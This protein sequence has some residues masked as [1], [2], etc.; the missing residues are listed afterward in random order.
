MPS[1][2]KFWNKSAFVWILLAACDTPPAPAPAFDP[3]PYHQA[4][5]KLGKT[6]DAGAQDCLACHQGI[7]DLSLG[8][9]KL[10]EE[11]RFANAE[12][13]KRAEKE[14]PDAKERQ[15]MLRVFGAHS[16]LDVLALHPNV[17]CRTCHVTTDKSEDKTLS[18]ERLKV[19]REYHMQYHPV[20]KDVAMRKTDRTQAVCLKC[21]LGDEPVPHADVLNRARLIYD[22][23]GCYACHTTHGMKT[24]E[25]DLAPGEK[26]MRRPGPP[27]ANIASK[28]DKRW[29]YNWVYVPPRFKPTARMFPF[30]P[31][32]PIGLP[33]QVIAVDPK[34]KLT[35]EAYGRVVV[36]CIVE[37]LY[38]K[39]K[40][41]DLP[42]IPAGLLET[43]DWKIE[44]QRTR[45]QAIAANIGC[46]ACHKFD[47]N[48]PPNFR[49]AMGFLED[50]FATNLYG[51]GDKFDSP[52]G[53][54]WLFHWLKKPHAFNSDSPMP[55][56]DLTDAEVAD[57]VQYLVSLKIDNAFRKQNQFET[58]EPSELPV[59][60]DHEPHPEWMKLLDA[61][62]A[63]QKG[64]ANAS[65]KDKILLVG[66]AM[67]DVFT[68]FSCHDLGESEW[69]DK[70][71]VW[72]A[73]NHDLFPTRGLMARMPLYDLT[74]DE[75]GLSATYMWAHTEALDGKPRELSARRKAMV[76]GERLLAKYNCAGCHI[77]EPTTLY[78]RDG[79][80]VLASAAQ[81]KSRVE[82]PP[83][84]WA[85]DWLRLPVTL[86]YSPLQKKHPTLVPEEL[87][88][89]FEQIRGGTYIS[90]LPPEPPIEDFRLPP[91]LRTAGRKFNPEW[92]RSFLRVPARM[93]PTVP[94]MPKFNLSAEEI[95]ALVEYFRARDG[96]TPD[97]AAG[98]LTEAQIDAR[99]PALAEAD[100]LLRTGCKQ[101]HMIDG[102]GGDMSVDLTEVHKRLQRPWLRAFL[103]EPGS[104][105]P[106]SVMP[107]LT[108][109]ANVDDVTDALLNYPLLRRAKVR[110]GDADEMKQA[111]PYVDDELVRLALD[112]IAN[113]PKLEKAAPA[114]IDVLMRKRLPFRAELEALLSHKSAG[115]RRLAIEGLARIA[116]K[117]SLPKIVERLADADAS[118]RTAALLA[119]GYFGDAPSVAKLLADSDP[120]VRKTA[121]RVLDEAGAGAADVAGRL[122]DE[123]GNVRILAAETLSSLGARDQ[124]PALRAALGDSDPDV[125]WAVLLALAHLGDAGDAK[126]LDHEKASIRAAA[127][128][129]LIRDPRGMAAFKKLI[130]EPPFDSM[131]QRALQ[132]AVNSLSDLQAG[133]EPG[134][135]TVA[136]WLRAIDAAA[137]DVDEDKLK[138][139]VSCR[140]KEL[141]VLARLLS[142]KTG[143]VFL[144]R[145][146]KL[147]FVPLDAALDKLK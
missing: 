73:I 124:I 17:D 37:Y 116:A 35:V 19:W 3:T 139:E 91:M 104:I 43:E 119:A 10:G 52:L 51:S 82:G 125:V 5:A 32:G 126:F 84:K 18:P 127:A 15:K 86:D 76:E 45:G 92:L 109:D 75:S 93:R 83:A 57:L 49:G 54:K 140:S 144:T 136:D 120:D 40:P 78:V 21:H 39:S 20:L 34:D 67:T 147:V 90:R 27:L 96:A 94:R 1:C 100:R 122:K 123:D 145:D 70:P 81:Y 79:G 58:W 117:E 13:Q 25:Q 129:C 6:A 72:G 132:H 8:T 113:D 118:V 135:R 11:I 111:L 22:R 64:P 62:Y 141:A 61:L 80:R 23:T 12:L 121:L 71:V 46:I 85:V 24:R 60:V 131:T 38:N 29:M 133:V 47:E 146:G 65:T 134:T 26:R 31:R 59:T 14:F 102:A 138:E 9:M 95:D 112:R 33:P 53:K 50:E 143:A 87:V 55:V 110:L 69:R 77:L 74:S 4:F 98:R 99:Y 101:C 105:Y 88:E 56:F 41:L 103:L 106:Q 48:Y 30:F 108:K 142:K 137:E 97:D 16:K 128:A 107:T 44:D 42:E 28:V 68:C 36:A 114:A 115:V 66:K 89:R 130:D 2:T 7:S 63:H